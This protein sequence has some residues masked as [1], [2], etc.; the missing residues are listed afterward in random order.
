MT[1]PSLT[2]APSQQEGSQPSSRFDRWVLPSLGVCTL[3]V[4]CI[5]LSLK[6]Q[7]WADEVFTRT[8][9]SDPSLLHL[10]HALTRLGG[11]GMP[12]FYLTAWP[13][14]HLF[15]MSDLSLRLYSCA[16][17]CGAF[18]VLTTALRHRFNARA[19]FLGVGFG[20]FAC[21]IVV[22]QNGEARGYGLYLLLCALAIA[23]IFRIAETP[24]PRARDLFLLA[25]SEAGVVLGH[26]L[27]LIFSGL[28]LVALVA[29]DLFQRRFR[30]KVY[31]AYMVGWLAILPWLP[32]IRAS[33]AVGKPHGWI[34]APTF[35]DL[36]ISVSYWLFAGIYFPLMK[37]TQFGVVAGWALA[38]FCVG[39]ILA[40]ASYGLREASPARR[41]I[42]FV[43]FALMLAPV[44]LYAVS[45]L[46]TPVWV[47]RY[48]IPAVLGVGI[49]AAG[50]AERAS[51][52]RGI[53]GLA[54]CGLVLLLPIADVA[55]AKPDSL[56]VAR[57]DQ[58]AAGRTVVSDWAPDFTVMLRYT[59]D[60]QPVEFV[61][62]WPNSLAGPPAAVG[63][64]HIMANYRRDGYMPGHLLDVDQ[65]LSQKTFLVLDTKNTNWFQLAIANNPR[66]AWKILAQIDKDRRLIEVNQ[67]N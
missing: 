18:L 59:T 25:L 42:Y 66:F 17:V 19:A 11:A 8:E 9:L 24:Q 65:V 44:A 45:H 37:G 12:L 38:I 7:E 51:F 41:A 22:D 4:S 52:V 62:D 26:V 33:V 13:W 43:G 64:Y 32:A 16:G 54:L 29:A 21:M 34:N 28:L 53:G 48:M 61:L 67:R 31:A 2:S 10:M 15:G 58:L 3:V 57:V 35:G 23:Q 55:L 14:A 6:K 27:G 5:L 36:V 39:W 30:A 56:D 1:T 60:P 46:V 40:S 49:V 20:L 50:W 47:A 63:G